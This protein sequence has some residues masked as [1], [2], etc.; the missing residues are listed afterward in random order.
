MSKTEFLFTKIDDNQ[1]NKI[2]CFLITETTLNDMQFFI[3]AKF[4]DENRNI[5]GFLKYQRLFFKQI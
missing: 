5:K 1:K 3:L 2:N 4:Y